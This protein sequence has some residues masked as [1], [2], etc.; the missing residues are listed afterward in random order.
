MDTSQERTNINSTLLS[1]QSPMAAKLQSDKHYYVFLVACLVLLSSLGSFVNDM[2]TPALPAM[3]RFFGCSVSL[4]QMGLTMGMAGLALGQFILGPV[5][6]RIGRRPVLVAS[7][8]LF[9]VSAVVSVFSP[10]IHVFNLCRLFQGIGASGGYF[11]ARTI[12]ADVYQGRA[13]ARLMALIG[14]INGIAPASAPVIGGITSDAFG[15]KGVFVLLAIFAVFLLFAAPVLK[16]SLP[17]AKRVSG[18]WMKSFSGYGSLLRNRPLIIHICFKGTALGMLFA[19]ISSSPFIL[20]SHYGLS[21]TSYGLVIG[22]NAIFMAAGSM[23][24]LKFKPFKKAA[25]TGAVV[26][27]VGVLAEAVA[28]Y[29]IHSILIYEI[30]SIVMLFGLGLIF[31]TANTLAMN[32]GRESAGEASALLGISGYVVGAAVSP[33]VGI[34]NV[35]HSTAITYVLLGIVVFAFALA[36]RRLA[37]DLN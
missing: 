17:V 10:S 2:Y 1:Q 18:P 6:D 20:Q 21:Q 31:T 24:A 11:L 3:C 12:P 25:Y 15:W 37:S 23:L 26:M 13:L 29:C 27:A 36:S 30:F 22:F 7:I 5:S 9:I 33:I 32:E 34:G 28:L 19:Y 8:V 4:G 14:A 35:L 16:E